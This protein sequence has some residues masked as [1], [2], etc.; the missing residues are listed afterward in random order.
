MGNGH[1]R[2]GCGGVAS[3][4]LSEQNPAV[5]LSCW[6]LDLTRTALDNARPSAASVLT[7]P[8]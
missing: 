4:K 8:R 2:R 6:R 3:G 7:V 1:F 5:A